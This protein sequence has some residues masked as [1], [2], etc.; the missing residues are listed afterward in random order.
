VR[1]AELIA[2]DRTAPHERPTEE[3]LA[4]PTVA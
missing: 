1:A 2:D 3:L 4:H